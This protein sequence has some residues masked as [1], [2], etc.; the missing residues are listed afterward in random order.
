MNYLTVKRFCYNTVGARVFAYWPNGYYY[1]GFV[2]KASDSKVLVYYDDGDNR[3]FDK[4]DPK[5]NVILDEIPQ[6]RYLLAEFVLAAT[7]DVERYASARIMK[8][9]NRDDPKPWA[10]HAY[11]VRGIDAYWAQFYQIRQLP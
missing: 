2:V 1:R 10:K 11:Y 9:G 7:S 8:V 6:K 5:I 4:N 3:W